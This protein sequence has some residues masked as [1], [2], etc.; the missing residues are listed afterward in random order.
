MHDFPVPREPGAGHQLVVPVELDGSGLAVD[1]RRHEI[2]EIARVER[3][4]VHRQA[5]RHVDVAD[6]PHS[7]VLD[8]LACARQ[9]AVPALLHRKIHDDAAGLHAVDH[10]LGD[11]HRRRPAGNERGGDDDVLLRQVLGHQRRLPEAVVLAH[12]LGVTARGL[13]GLGLLALDHHEGRSE[14]LDLLLHRGTDVGGADDGAEAARGRN[15]LQPRHPGPEHEHPGGRHRAGRGHHH[16][17]RAR[18]LR[19]GVD[20]RLV[21]RE[22]RLRR[23]DVHRLRAADPRD[24]LHRERVDAR[25]GV[26]VHSFAGAVGREHSDERRARLHRGQLGVGRSPDLEHQVGAGEKRRAAV[27]NPGARRVVV[28]VRESGA[29][30]RAAL[31]HHLQVE[32]AELLRGLGRERDPGLLRMRLLRYRQLHGF[33]PSLRASELRGTPGGAGRSAEA[34][35]HEW[36]ASMHPARTFLAFDQEAGTTTSGTRI[37][38]RLTPPCTP[39][40][41]NGFSSAIRSRMA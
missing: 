6:D 27:G 28:G 10:L 16:R 8:D 40:W 41:R 4:R 1:E 26:G 33:G 7:V 13:G 11:E 9:R 34:F 20:H 30:P 35:S 3:R 2:V 22:I 21:P 19:R 31:D 18:E 25:R 29:G 32:G 17:H 37:S 23:E 14:A 12:L 24:E 36:P 39:T 5:P 15:R 38:S